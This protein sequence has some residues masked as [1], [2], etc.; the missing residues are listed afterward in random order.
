MK[1][2]G[3]DYGVVVSTGSN[4]CIPPSFAA[5]TKGKKIVNIEGSIRFTRASKT[6]RILSPFASITAL[7]WEEQKSLLP[8]GRVFGPIIPR[9]EDEIK[10]EGFILVTGGT[11]GHKALFDAV[12]K[13]NLENVVLQTGRLDQ[14]SY[15]EAHPNWVIMDYSSEFHKYLSSAHAVITHFG[16]T[17]LESTLVYNKPTIIAV[18]PEWTRTV[19]ARDASILASK[20]NAKLL[21][22]I[23][24]DRVIQT[25]DEALRDRKHTAERGTEKLADAILSLLHK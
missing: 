3:D 17:I 12:S 5:L 20:V 4:F 2:V 24:P 11:Y 16:E 6:A 21:T 19:G 10:D 14:K 22:D 1:L 7:Q 8:R 15:R 18:N 13:T 9:P 23:T 25:I